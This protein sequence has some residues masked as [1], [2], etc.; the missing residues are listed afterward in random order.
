MNPGWPFPCARSLPKRRR[1]RAEIARYLRQAR[2]VACTP[3]QIVIAAGTQL[4]IQQLCCLFGLD[5]RAVAIEE[6]GY[7]GVRIVFQHLGF[8]VT[9]IPLEEDGI[10]VEALEESGARLVYITPSH[11]EPSGMVMP[12]A[13]RIRLLQWAA[14]TGGYIVED[15]YDGEFRYRGKPIPSDAGLS[16]TVEV[17]S[18][19]TAEELTA[20][21]ASAGIRVYPTAPKFRPSQ[22]RL[23]AFQFGF[24][25]LSVEEMDAGLRLLYEVWKPYMHS[26]I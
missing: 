24:G 1:L 5:G 3:D 25:G 23:P 22:N 16:V 19:K 14:R 21:A 18:D 15:D 8:A 26:C 17:Y 20:A 9:P 7:N 2:G 13:K 4:L 11:Q 12:Y 6:P 10:D